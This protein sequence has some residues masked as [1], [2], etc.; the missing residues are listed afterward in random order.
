MPHSTADE[1]THGAEEHDTVVPDAPPLDRA[2][3]GSEDG[4]DGS[5]AQTSQGHRQEVKL[6]DLFNDDEDDDDE[7]ATSSAPVDDGAKSPPSAP[8]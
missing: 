6:E 3:T 4:T 8:V 1:L 7:F 5:V 2:E